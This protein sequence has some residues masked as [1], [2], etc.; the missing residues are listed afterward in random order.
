M[1]PLLGGEEGRQLENGNARLG[2]GKVE[3]A[4][5]EAMVERDGHR[6][7]AAR[8]GRFNGFEHG[9]EGAG[10]L[11]PV[12]LDPAGFDRDRARLAA[13]MAVDGFE[14]RGHAA[15]RAAHQRSRQARPASIS[16]AQTI[17]SD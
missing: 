1:C 8:P 16:P 15:G 17:G 9:G 13:R 10:E 4:C 5:R 12:Q 11:A 7:A 14:Q 6:P 2:Q 3:Q